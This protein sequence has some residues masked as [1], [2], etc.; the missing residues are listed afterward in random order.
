LKDAAILERLM[1]TVW[2]TGR[3]PPVWQD[4]RVGRDRRD[5]LLE[6]GRGLR[7]VD[8][9]SYRGLADRVLSGRGRLSVCYSDRTRAGDQ[10]SQHRGEQYSTHHPS[11]SKFR[12]HL[13][14]AATTVCSIAPK[15][16]HPA[17]VIASMRTVSP[18]CMK[19]M[20]GLP[21]AM[22]SIARCSE[23]QLEPTSA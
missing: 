10:R 15:T 19:P 6:Y 7:I 1:P 13:R 4:H 5:E 16:A 3:F 11:P 14:W 12:D 21:L 22:I 18:N 2:D 8:Q 20:V 9:L 23:M 17:G